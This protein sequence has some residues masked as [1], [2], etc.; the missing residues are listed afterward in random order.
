MNPKPLL[1][2]PISPEAKIITLQ[3]KY[4]QRRNETG[5]IAILRIEH[6]YQKNENLGT[7]QNISLEHFITD[8]RVIKATFSYA[9]ADASLDDFK[10]YTWNTESDTV[11]EGTNTDCT[12]ENLCL[13]L[14]PGDLHTVLL[15]LMPIK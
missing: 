12:L 3:K 14:Q 11:K 9:G 4:F 7:V 5:Q 15:T 2:S 8:H 10:R 13:L 6:I 1:T